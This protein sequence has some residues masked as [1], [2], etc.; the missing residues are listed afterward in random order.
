MNTLTAPNIFD[1]AHTYL[2]IGGGDG[3]ETCIVTGDRLEDAYLRM[4]F[5]D[6]TQYPTDCS[7][8]D[9]LN[10]LRDDDGH[11]ESNWYYGPTRYRKDFED[12]YV[13]VIRLVTEIPS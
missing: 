13:E 6:E 3:Y 12:G 11:W 5:G 10:D 1:P 7:R 4:I 8:D 9:L 2:V